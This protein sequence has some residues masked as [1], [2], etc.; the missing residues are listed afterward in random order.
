MTVWWNW[1][2]KSPPYVAIDKGYD[3][4]GFVCAVLVVVSAGICVCW[5]VAPEPA[6]TPRPGQ[7]TVDTRFTHPQQILVRV[8]PDDTPQRFWYSIITLTNNANREVD[9]YPKCEL[10]TDTFE[11]T[12][13]GKTVTPSVFAAIKNRHNSVYPFLE[14]LEQTS[15]KI[16]R[17]EDNTKDIAVIWPDFDAQAKQIKLFITGLSNESA[18]VDHPVA[19]DKDGNPLKVFLRKTL[20]LTYDLQ[21]D[22]A[23]RTDANLVY[24]AKR[25]VMR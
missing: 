22:P 15:S 3:M 2:A 9:F 14:S 23:M 20:E 11:I 24:K 25:W 7:W 21:S 18:M 12:A 16:L 5:A 8:G 17:G 13:A 6:A 4:R 19:K 10:M 1:W